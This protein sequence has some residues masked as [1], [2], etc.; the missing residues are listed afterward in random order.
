MSETSKK[1]GG[2]ASGGST[3]G[4]STTPTL[5]GAPT[6]LNETPASGAG[7]AYGP[8]SSRASSS[9]SGG[10]DHFFL[11]DSAG[12]T[13]QSS[14]CYPSLEKAKTGSEE[15]GWSGVT[16]MSV[17]AGKCPRCGKQAS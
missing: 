13:L 14:T 4:T 15:Q 11:T 1:S 7:S 16:V 2:S 6:R 12:S 17:V 3:S 9:E 10:G 8:S 5:E